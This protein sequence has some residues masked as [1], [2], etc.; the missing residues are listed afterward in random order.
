MLTTFAMAFGTLIN[1]HKSKT[2]WMDNT[3]KDVE[4][5]KEGDLE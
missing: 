4:W 2:I 1:S 5:E 3:P